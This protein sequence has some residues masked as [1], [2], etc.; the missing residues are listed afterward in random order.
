MHKS[1]GITLTPREPRSDWVKVTQLEVGRRLTKC[2]NI[3]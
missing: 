1:C 2:W 3:F